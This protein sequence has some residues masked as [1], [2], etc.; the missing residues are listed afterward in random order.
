MEMEFG[1]HLPDRDWEL[2]VE[3]E[4]KKRPASP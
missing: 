3:G 4:R 1:G 2:T